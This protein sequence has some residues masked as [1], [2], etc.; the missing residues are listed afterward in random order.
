MRE[1]LI[2]AAI[3]RFGMRG[4]EAVGTREIAAAVGTPMS[5]ITYHFGGKEGLYVA[6]AEHIFDSIQSVT[7]PALEEMPD[8]DA[9]REE[10]VDSVC[11][12]LKTMARFML[13]DGSAAFALFIMREQQ[14]PTPGVLELMDRKV[15]PM[16][17]RLVEQVKILR[18]ELSEEQA[19]AI[20]LYL[21]GMTITLRHGRTSICLL[22]DCEEV[23]EATQELLLDQ[24][25]ACDRAILNAGAH[26]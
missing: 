24:M 20:S 19:K 18:P 10:I 17:R 1:Q 14:V 13:D 11:A 23:D 25:E 12:S 3:E 4:F 2:L 21:F 6:A 5:S 22:L 16:L 26:G 7:T 15:M 8:S 9:S